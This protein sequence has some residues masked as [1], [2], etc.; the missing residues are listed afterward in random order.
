MSRDER[1]DVPAAMSSCSTS[2]ARIPRDTASSSAPAADDPAA[3]DDDVPGLGVSAARGRRPGGARAVG[4]AGAGVGPAARSSLGR[5]GRPARD[6]PQQ[7][8]RPDDQDDDRQRRVEDDLLDVRSAGRWSGS[9]RPRTTATDDRRRRPRTSRQPGWLAPHAP[10][11]GLQPR[12]ASAGM[13]IGATRTLPAWAAPRLVSSPVFG[14][15][16]GDGQVGQ[17]GRVRRLAAREVDGGRRV[18]RDDRDAAPPG[19]GR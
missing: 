16:E 15:V 6:A 17:D 4:L 10:R 2:A 8:R 19:P 9:P 1:D 14:P 3:D 5:A 18:D 7:P 11:V 12:S 13:P